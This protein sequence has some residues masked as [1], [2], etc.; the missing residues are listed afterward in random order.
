MNWQHCSHV[1]FFPSHSYEQYYQS[2]RRCWR[3]G[4]KS[5]V[6]VDIVTTEGE[7]RVLKNL[8][9]K[10]KA[11]DKMFTDLM[12]HMNNALEI[13]TKVYDSGSINIPAWIR[14]GD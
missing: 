7:Y 4:Q 10:A 9:R 3:F 1:S 5:P 13:K 14:K 2:V 8:K 11:A 12:A 6:V